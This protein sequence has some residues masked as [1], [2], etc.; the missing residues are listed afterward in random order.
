LRSTNNAAKRNLSGCVDGELVMGEMN[1]VDHFG[2]VHRI[3]AQDM[4]D[5]RS[6]W[7]KSQMER[8]SNKCKTNTILTWR[9]VT[10]LVRDITT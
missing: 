9:I 4:N 10:S 2:I 6:Q 5:S 3:V 7:G 8:E 1:T